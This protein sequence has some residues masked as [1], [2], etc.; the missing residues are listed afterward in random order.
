M[1]DLRSRPPKQPIRLHPLPLVKLFIEPPVHAKPRLVQKPLDLSEQGLTFVKLD[2]GRFDRDGVDLGQE[3]GRAL[4]HF[5]LEPCTSI[6]S[7]LGR[8]SARRS[9]IMPT[10]MCWSL[11]VVGAGEAAHDVAGADEVSHRTRSCSAR[12]T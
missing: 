12:T 11:E 7:R 8:A 10:S 3:A 2:I 4:E 9:S 1:I 5:Q 6:F